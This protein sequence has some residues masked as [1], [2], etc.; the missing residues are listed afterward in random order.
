MVTIKEALDIVE[1]HILEIEDTRGI[2]PHTYRADHK[3]DM[4]RHA[5]WGLREA[6]GQDGDECRGHPLS[7]MCLV[8]PK[9]SKE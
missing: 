2:D 1:T 8:L 4:L 5:R 3:L 6:L 9:V 7:S